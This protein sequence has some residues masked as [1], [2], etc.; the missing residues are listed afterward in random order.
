M[1]GLDPTGSCRLPE[2]GGLH[3]INNVE[4]SEGRAGNNSGGVTI[5]SVDPTRRLGPSMLVAIT[6]P[7]DIRY[8]PTSASF[9]RD[10]PPALRAAVFSTLS[11]VTAAESH[12]GSAA[13]SAVRAQACWSCQQE[14]VWSTPQQVGCEAMRR[15]GSG[16]SWPVRFEAELPS[17]VTVLTCGRA[18]GS[19][20]V[21][22]VGADPPLLPHPK[23]AEKP[24]NFPVDRSSLHADN[25]QKLSHPTHRSRKA[26]GEAV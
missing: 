9:S 17:S 12:G 13:A 11:S 21:L 20:I 4:S 18:A 3:V 26:D 22:Q 5:R 1:A 15:I 16:S 14:G 10:S 8:F 24:R 23:L 7:P 25:S 6:S 2:A 19:R